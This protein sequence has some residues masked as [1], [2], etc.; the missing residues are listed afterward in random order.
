[1]TLGLSA[2]R[3][4]LAG[5]AA[6]PHLT[7]RAGVLIAPQTGQI[8]AGTEA[9]RP[10]PIAS[11]TKL[12]TALVVLQHVRNLDTV[13][14]EPNYY[15]AAAD[16]QIGLVPGERMTVRDLLVAL[17]LPSADDAAEDLAYNIGRGPGHT[18]L[19]AAVAHFV[20]MMNAEARKL[21]LRQ[22]HYATPIGLDTP[23]NYS[24]ATDLVRLAGYDMTHFP[25][26]TRTVALPRAVLHSGNQVRYV[27]NRNSLVGRFPWIDGV[28]TG[29][30]TAA[31][32][33]LVASGQ[34]GGMRLIDAVLGT[35]SEASRD[36]NALALLDYGF[37]NFRQVSPL[38]AGQVLARPT[39][40]YRSGTHATL[41]AATAVTRVVPRHGVVAIRVAAPRQLTGPLP[42]HAV[43][44]TATVL[45]DGRPVDRIPLILAKAL[46]EV[47]PLSIAAGFIFRP[48]PLLI[49]VLLAGGGLALASQ[50]RQRRR[51]RGKGGLRPA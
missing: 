11:T 49:I 14:T 23:G 10:L 3:P 28:K 48:L 29:H 40:Q 51:V 24:T 9:N 7:A 26:F 41:L 32:Y 4:A 46:P 42:R 43:L 50:V 5:A 37:A 33:V 6:P 19:S 38:H 47:S 1:M 35:S 45:L 36:A 21:G 13:F 39:V 44:G 34:R 8:L 15:P 12:M 30:T 18:A 22:T 27:I 25:F 17:M 31:G 2:T 20:A 16:S